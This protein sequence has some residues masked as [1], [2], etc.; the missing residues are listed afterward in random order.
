[1]VRDFITYQLGRNEVKRTLEKNSICKDILLVNFQSGQRDEGR[2]MLSYISRD[3][4]PQ[5]RCFLT[6][7]ERQWM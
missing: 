1:M 5:V 2:I 7:I 6:P 3:R 4:N